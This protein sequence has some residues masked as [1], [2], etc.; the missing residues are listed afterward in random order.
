MKVRAGAQAIDASVPPERNVR[1]C[2]RSPIAEQGRA[3]LQHGSSIDTI[4]CLAKFLKPSLQVPRRLIQSIVSEHGRGLV[5]R[6]A[7][8]ERK[9]PHVNVGTIGHVDHGKTTLTA[10]LTKI[11][12]DKGM[13]KFISYDEVGQSEREPRAPG[14]PPRS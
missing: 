13:A 10:A 5:W 1:V 3:H 14:M 8:Y 11:C 12:A 9:K 6:P 7:K 2:H 4:R